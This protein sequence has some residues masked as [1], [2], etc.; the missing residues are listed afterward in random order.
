MAVETALSLPDE[1]E[2]C[3]SYNRQED[4][5]MGKLNDDELEN[6]SGG[7]SRENK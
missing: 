7:T 4:I 2:K 6:V 5:L 3:G 1:T